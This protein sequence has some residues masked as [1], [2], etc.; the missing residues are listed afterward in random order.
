MKKLLF[1]VMLAFSISIGVNAQDKEKIKKTSTPPQ[2]IHN[3]VSK[4]NKYKGYKV[5]RKH[6]GVTKKHKVN[7]QNGEVKNKTDK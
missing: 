1:L 5:K 2:K 6:H 4:H 7:L 3:A